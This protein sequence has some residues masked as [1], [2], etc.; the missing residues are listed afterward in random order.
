MTARGQTHISRVPLPYRCGGGGG[1]PM[2]WRTKLRY[3]SY[4]LARF[5]TRT[6]YARPLRLFVTMWC[7]GAILGAIVTLVSA[8]LATQ[9]LWDWAEAGWRFAR[10][11]L[12]FAVNAENGMVMMGSVLASLGPER[13]EERRVGKECRSRRAARR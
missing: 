1:R 3:V 13:S 4:R 2:R 12:L 6:T 11:R 8:D 7:I 5:W 10:G 9:R